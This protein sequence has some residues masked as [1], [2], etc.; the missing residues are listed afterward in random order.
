MRDGQTPTADVRALA[1]I[2]LSLATA[3]LLA[4]TVATFL[5]ST[6]VELANAARTPHYAALETAGR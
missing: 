5:V 1:A 6:E 3:A 4:A 2:G